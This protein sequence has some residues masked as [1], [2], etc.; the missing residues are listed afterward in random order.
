MHAKACHW[1]NG[2]W[3]YSTRCHML[4]PESPEAMLPDRALYLLGFAL[5]AVL[6]S[7]SRLRG[8]GCRVPII[9]GGVQFKL[10]LS[11]QRSC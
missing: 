11:G 6:H 4:A 10:H 8:K 1:P 2:E 7:T 9:K 3:G 5:G